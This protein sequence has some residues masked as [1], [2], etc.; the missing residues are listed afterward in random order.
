MKQ[1]VVLTPNQ[2][3]VWDTLSRAEAPLGAYALLD[4]LK[5]RNFR[6]PLQVYRALDKQWS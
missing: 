5:G 4:Q 2:Q 6:A 1:H 3:A